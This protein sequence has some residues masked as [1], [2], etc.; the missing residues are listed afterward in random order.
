MSAV[1]YA[2]GK[3]ASRASLA[4]K[5]CAVGPADNRPVSRW[6][7]K[8][9]AVAGFAGL[10]GEAR[11]SRRDVAARA[12]QRLFRGHFERVL[13]LPHIRN[14]ARIVRA[15]PPAALFAALLGVQ[16]RTPPIGLCIP[17]CAADG[18]CIPPSGY[19]F[20]H[21]ARSGRRRRR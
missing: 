18:S 11:E 14:E 1:G 16:V 20:L 4:S 15:W 7:A 12:V 21:R 9:A 3:A 8:V 19:A 6:R 2:D 17:A 10:I 13:F 5:T